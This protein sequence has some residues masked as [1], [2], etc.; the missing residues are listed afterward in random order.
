MNPPVQ[1]EEHGTFPEVV[2]I[3][4]P[5]T[6]DLVALARFTAA[7]LAAKADFDVEEIEDLRLAVDELCVMMIR[8][9]GAGRLALRFERE[10][11]ELEVSCTQV[12]APGS[13]VHREQMT[14]DDGLSERILDALVDQHGSRLEGGEARVW[15]RKRQA[16][17][18]A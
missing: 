12:G 15:L 7:T 9:G 4:L 17:Q 8:M 11:D 16:R 13:T 2:E 6:A 18:R 10:R 3:T 1:V 5:A 14:A